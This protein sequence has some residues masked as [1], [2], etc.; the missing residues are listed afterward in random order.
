[1]ARHFF[2]VPLVAFLAAASSLP[3]GERTQV[4]Y[5]KTDRSI[6][7]QP[8]FKSDKPEYGLLLFGRQARLRVWLAIDGDT[9]YLDRNGNG[10][11]T[12]DGER[13]EKQADCK[14]VEVKDADGQTRYVITDLRVYREKD[15][16]PSLSAEIA[17][18]G[19]VAYQQYCD[20]TLAATP[21]KAAIA[22]FHGPLTAGPRTLNWKVVREVAA[23]TPGEKP[24]NFHAWI[25]TMSEKHGC[26]VVVRTHEGEKCLF[27]DGVRPKVTI[28]FPAKSVGAP[29]IR[30]Q[31]TLD[32]FC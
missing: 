9:I 3:A 11:L 32:E 12:D 24:G 28:E 8:K 30:R 21:G 25:G 31:Y 1:M 7:K 20:L 10:D 6:G 5:D 29:S 4:D 27:A 2:L 17:I 13:F 15:S 16:P 19:R 18:H 26:W 22:H 14:D 23:L